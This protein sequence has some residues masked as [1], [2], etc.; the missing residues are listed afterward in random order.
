[1]K[2][3]QNS[4]VIDALKNKL[5]EAAMERRAVESKLASAEQKRQDME[6]Q[7]RELLGISG[8]KEEMVQRLQGRVEEVVQEMT[9]LSAQ[10]DTAKADGR[11]QV[12]HAKERATNKVTAGVLIPIVS[13]FPACPYSQRVPSVSL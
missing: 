6:Q 1:M 4:G 11:K 8:R 9:L 3:E 2:T 7:N 10:V 12:E 13:V 5:H